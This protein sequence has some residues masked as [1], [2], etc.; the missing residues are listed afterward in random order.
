MDINDALKARLKRLE[1][2]KRTMKPIDK[3]DILRPVHEITWPERPEEKEV[4]K[5]IAV[6]RHQPMGSGGLFAVGDFYE[7]SVGNLSSDPLKLA[8][9]T[10]KVAT[11]G[12]ELDGANLVTLSRPGVYY[13]IGRAR[14]DTTTTTDHSGYINMY[15]NSV[16][17]FNANHLFDNYSQ[18]SV[19]AL[20]ASGTTVLD[21]SRITMTVHGLYCVGAGDTDYRLQEVSGKGRLGLAAT[22]T[23]VYGSATYRHNFA[24]LTVYRLR[25]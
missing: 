23:S 17:S 7:T 25:G 14:F 15:I 16:D 20:G 22:Y 1:E 13:V 19:G 12:V 5:P 10:E 4:P 6:S 2:H 3:S 11:G 9:S 18:L 21:L 24:Q 8:F